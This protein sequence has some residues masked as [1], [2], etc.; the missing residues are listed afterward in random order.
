MCRLQNNH[1]HSN[2]SVYVHQKQNI[3]FLCVGKAHT[4]FPDVTARE[5][6]PLFFYIICVMLVCLCV[7]CCIVQQLYIFH[8][9]LMH[10]C[11]LQLIHLHE[12]CAPSHHTVYRKI[13][14][15]CDRMPFCI[16]NTHTA[17][18]P[19]NN[20]TSSALKH[21]IHYGDE[22]RA[23][24]SSAFSQTTNFHQEQLMLIARKKISTPNRF[25]SL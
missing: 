23:H 21:L 17:L 20:R 19:I 16:P 14:K 13:L 5:D 9:T 8:H 7:C 11:M 3:I 18:S 12:T 2:F 1:I 24:F 15:N 22:S 4:F 6:T 25:Q 10:L